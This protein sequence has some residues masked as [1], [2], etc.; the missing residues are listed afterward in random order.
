MYKVKNMIFSPIRLIN[1]TIGKRGRDG[2]I[3]ISKLTEQIKNLEKKGFLK[4]ITL[5]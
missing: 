3:T 1:I 5:S 2:Y 4:I